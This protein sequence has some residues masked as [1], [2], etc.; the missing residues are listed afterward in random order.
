MQYSSATCVQVKEGGDRDGSTVNSQRQVT[1]PAPNVCGG[2]DV[3]LVREHNEDAFYVSGD[4]RLLVVADGMGGH[5]AGEVASALAVDTLRDVLQATRRRE[6]DAG[7]AEAAAVLRAAFDAAHRRVLEAAEA[8]PECR[9]M[10]TT[11]ILGYVSGDALHTCH[12]GDVRCYIR[13]ADGLLQVTDDH[14]VVAALV[15]SGKLSPAAAR[16]HTRRHEILQAVGLGS[17]IT[18]DVHA[19]GLRPG[20]LVLLCSDGLWE[21]VPDDQIGAILDNGHSLRDRVQALLDGANRAGGRDNVTV[22]L[23]QH[24]GAA[25]EGG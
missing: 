3:G 5:M 22:V 25:A 2:T 18:A 7:E 19:R 23:Y 15:R 1:E 13:G 16:V 6:M 9:G 21:M 24:G 14:S 10:G 17:G 8:R 11:L 12:V 20:D 4:G